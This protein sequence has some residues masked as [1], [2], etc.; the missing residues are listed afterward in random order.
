MTMS[1]ETPDGHEAVERSR[2]VEA[3][4]AENLDIVLA[5]WARTPRTS[6]PAR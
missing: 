2:T 3:E 6:A 1:V 4:A 5:A